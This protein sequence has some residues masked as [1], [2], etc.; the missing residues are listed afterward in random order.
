[1]NKIFEK[2][3]KIESSKTISVEEDRINDNFEQKLKMH[4]KQQHTTDEEL[5]NEIMELIYMGK[6]RFM[7]NSKTHAVRKMTGNW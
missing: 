6:V 1:M 4:K 5:D 2:A 3:R 7:E